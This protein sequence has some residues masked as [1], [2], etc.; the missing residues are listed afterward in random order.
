MSAW[1]FVSSCPRVR[2][3]PFTPFR[4]GWHEWKSL[5]ETI[6]QFLTVWE[7]EVGCWELTMGTMTSSLNNTLFRKPRR[8]GVEMLQRRGDAGAKELTTHR[9]RLESGQDATFELPGEESIV[10]LQE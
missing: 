9:V 10:V 6:T 3:V 4:P 2:P 7:L 5:N 1:A 8:G